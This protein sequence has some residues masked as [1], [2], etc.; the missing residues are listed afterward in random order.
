MSESPTD[1]S[2]FHRPQHIYHPQRLATEDVL[3]RA[4]AYPYLRPDDSFLYDSGAVRP[5]PFDFDFSAGRYNAFLVVGSN[6]APDQLR[7]K[8]GTDGVLIPVLRARCT[9]LDIVYGPYV[10]FYGSVPS[11][12]VPSPHTVLHTHVILLDAALTA[13]MNATEVSYHVCRLSPTAPQTIEF[14][15]AHCFSK[16]IPFSSR[17][18]FIYVSMFGALRTQGQDAS[19]VALTFFKAHRRTFPDMDQVGI[20]NYVKD[21]L[22]VS[23]TLDN[24]IRK[25]VDCKDLEVFRDIRNKLAPQQASFDSPSD[26]PP[27]DDCFA[28]VQSLWPKNMKL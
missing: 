28:L 2:T 19:P 21:R 7:R 18:I 17:D 10:V 27:V 12:I 20:L 11:T 16:G 1:N 8:Y 5:I 26:L 4:K 9:H 23:D 24:W 6:A 14:E 25:M 22:G 13:T 15:D 3:T